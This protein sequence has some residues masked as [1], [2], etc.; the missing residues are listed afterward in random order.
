MSLLS[1]FGLTTAT[2]RL[3]AKASQTAFGAAAPIGWNVDRTFEHPITGAAAT[4]LQKGDTYILAFRGTDD[5]AD[6]AQ[7]PFLA[8]GQY[9]RFFDS[10]LNALPSGAKYYVTGAS[11]GGGATNLLADVAATA[12]GGKFANATFVAFASPNISNASRIANIGFEN[13]PVFK[14]LGSY[15]N[16]A[17]SLDN[18]VLATKEYMA[19]NY[20]GL[21]PFDDYAHSAR[22]GFSAFDRLGQS[23]Y[24]NVMKP[25]SVVIFAATDGK[26]QDITPGRSFVGAFYLGTAA[27]DVMVGR[28]GNDFLEGFGG[29]D[30]LRGGA[31]A[32][33]LRGDSGNDSLIGGAGNDVIHG[34]TGKDSLLGD[35]G[36]DFFVF[37][38]LPGGTNV[39]TIRDFNP[40]D[41]TIRPD[42]AVFPEVGPNG[43]LATQAFWTGTEAHDAT[44]RIVYD[45]ATGAVYYDPDGTGLAPQVRFAQ[46]AKGLAVTAADF[47]VI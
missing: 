33:R 40:A 10:L 22:L 9:L 21:L 12:Y 16:F 2:V 45:P 6:V 43:A 20:N 41:D 26:V 18:L 1:P 35:A 38:K 24:Y 13:D 15:G 46:L 8:T 47:V 29:A 19:G 37:D 11:L 25:D 34:G 42:N 17:S 44:D 39:D 4:V 23:A 27:A 3:M 31:G 32:D 28:H 36:R 7:Y 30:V 5:A 14:A